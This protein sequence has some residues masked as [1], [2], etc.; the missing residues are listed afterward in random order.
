MSVPGE[1]EARV[2]PSI[3][4]VYRV[5]LD[6]RDEQRAMRRELIGRPEYESDQEGHVAA[7]KELGQRITNV[8]KD[9]EG[10]KSTVK[11]VIGVAVTVLAV[12]LTYAMN[13]VG[14]HA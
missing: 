5:V 4:E 12:F 10:F 2:E 7:H 13:H 9:F 8:V 6:V 14:W 11:W 3:G 1:F